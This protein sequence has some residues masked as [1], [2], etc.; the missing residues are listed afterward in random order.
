MGLFRPAELP[1]TAPG[2]TP[3]AARFFFYFESEDHARRAADQLETKGYAVEVTAP[4]AEV[5]SWE[6]IAGGVPST[7][8]IEQAERIFQKWARSAGG[9]YD[10]NEVAVGD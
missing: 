3:E 5:E 6:V 1:P 2:S 8:D 7:E 4:D 10:G 9:D